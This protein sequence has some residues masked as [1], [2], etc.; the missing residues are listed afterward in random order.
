MANTWVKKLKK[1]VKSALTGKAGHSKAGKK[2]LARIK[3]KKEEQKDFSYRTR[4]QLD[5][6]SD[7]DYKAVMKA[8]GGK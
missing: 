1:N 2:E 3:S 8:M 6:L 7:A 4:R 5:G